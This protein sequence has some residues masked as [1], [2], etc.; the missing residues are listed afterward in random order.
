MSAS[1]ENTITTLFGALKKNRD[2]FLVLSIVS[3]VLGTIGLFMAFAL[4]LATVLFSG[5]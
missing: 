2:W 3:T 5:V 1:H 4:K